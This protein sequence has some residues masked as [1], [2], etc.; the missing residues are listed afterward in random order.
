MTIHQTPV[1][2]IPG[3]AAFSDFRSQALASLVGVTDVRGRYLHYVNLEKPLQEDERGL[4]EKLLTNG[5][6]E[7]PTPAAGKDNVQV[8]HVLPR[9]GTISPWSSKA[10]NIAHVCGLRSSIRRIER[11]TQITIILKDGQRLEKGSL[12]DFLHDRM[13]ETIS[14]SDPNFDLLFAQQAPGRLGVY[15]LY[16]GAEAPVDVLKRLNKPAR[17][18]T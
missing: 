6:V 16:N 13:T 2:V 4:L 18:G 5:Q 12:L 8:F 15:D 1:L 14:E 7:E 17:S 10:T 3:A 11:G 9:P